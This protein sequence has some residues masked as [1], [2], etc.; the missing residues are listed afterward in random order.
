MKSLRGRLIAEIIA[1]SHERASGIVVID[2]K[3][4][5]TRAKVIDVGADSVSMT[6]RVLTSPAKVNDIIYFKQFTPMLH[7]KD[8]SESHKSGLITVWWEDIIAVDVQ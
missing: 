4:I 1:L 8:G 5:S 7:G 3:N 2:R 6:G